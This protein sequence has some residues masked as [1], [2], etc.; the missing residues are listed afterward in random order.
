MT[1]KKALVTGGARGIGKATALELARRGASIAVADKR[2]EQAD[3]T[4]EECRGEGVTA[5]ALPLDQQDP[6]SAVT[7]V[8]QAATQLGGLDMVFANAGIGKFRPFIEIS[9]DEWR[10]TIDVNLNGTF[11]VCQAAAQEM[12]RRSVAGAIVLTASS[13]AMYVADQLSAYCVSKA[14]VLMLGKQMASE[15]GPYRIRVNAVMPGVVESPMTAS[16]LQE[17]KWGRM[18][19]RQTPAGRAGQPGDVARLVAFLL[20]DEA[21]YIN[22]TGVLIDGGSTLHGYPRWFSLDYGDSKSAD[23]E[24]LFDAYPYA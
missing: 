18:V 23:W 16:M 3:E 6:E 10:A 15:L 2:L 14:G 20:S 5:I 11:Y 1:G 22:G 7:C 19:R 21:S 4:A 17:E 12:I 24:A 13:G 8:D 9:A